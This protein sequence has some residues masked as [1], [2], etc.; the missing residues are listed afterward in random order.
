MKLEQHVNFPLRLDITPFSFIG[1]HHTE[2]I[3]VPTA[4]Q[5]HA[6]LASS[7]PQLPTRRMTKANGIP[8]VAAEALSS[9]PSGTSPTIAKALQS[10]QPNPGGKGPIFG[11]SAEGALA[12]AGAWDGSRKVLNRLPNGAGS[13]GG[14][15]PEGTPGVIRR[16][17]WTDGGMSGYR[18]RDYDLG[19][20]IVHQ[21][22]ADSGHYTAFRRLESGDKTVRPRNTEVSVHGGGEERH[23][24]DISDETVRG[25]SE[26]EVL[27]SQAYMLFYRKRSARCEGLG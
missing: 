25:V 23:W 18:G 8:G 27:A 21:G 16:R 22:S 19:A 4:L 3:G 11:G 1:G 13:V 2:S 12:G 20:V 6:T 24:V 15:G 17:A 26:G 10:P 7:L 14:G 9:S 5:L